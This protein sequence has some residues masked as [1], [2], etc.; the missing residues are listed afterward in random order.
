MRKGLKIGVLGEL[1]FSQNWICFR[2]GVVLYLVSVW[3]ACTG[4]CVVFCGHVL[5]CT[6][7]IYCDAC[8]RIKQLVQVPF[9]DSGFLPTPGMATQ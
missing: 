8:N 3:C 1:L 5:T 6:G 2:I 9:I 4:G 7:L